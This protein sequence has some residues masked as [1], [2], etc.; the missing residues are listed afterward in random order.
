VALELRNL[1]LAG[2]VGI[3]FG[4]VLDDP[5]QRLGQQP[6]IDQIQ[7]QAHGQGAQ[8]A[9]NENDHRT[10]DET[11]AIGGGVEGDAQV[12]VYSL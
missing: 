9:G 12:A 1:V 4:E 5:R 6:V 3:D 8:Y 7:H 11:L 2:A 10:D